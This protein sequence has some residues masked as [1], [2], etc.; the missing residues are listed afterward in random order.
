MSGIAVRFCPE[1]S[2]PSADGA[3]RLL[4]AIKQRGAD[5]QIAAVVGR[6]EVA[7][8]AFH[9]SPEAAAE[10][11]P[12]HHPTL[13][14]WLVADA[15][16]D[17]RVALKR[18][19]LDSGCSF[20]PHTDAE[21]ILAAHEV[22]GANAQ[23][24]LVGDFAYVLWANGSLLAARDVMGMRPLVWAVCA[25]GGL[26]I[27]STLACV[28][29]FFGPTPSINLRHIAETL[30]NR[31]SNRTDTPYTGV[32]RLGPGERLVLR[33]GASPE[34]Q[35]IDELK[36]G[37]PL[38]VDAEQ[39]VN[40]V[41]DMLATSVRDR[42]RSIGGIACEVSGGLDS[43]TVFGLTCDVVGPSRITALSHTYPGMACDESG[44]IDAVVQS[45]RTESIA[46]D[47]SFTDPREL[48]RQVAADGEIPRYPDNARELYALAHRAGCRVVLTGQGGDE[49][50]SYSAGVEADLFRERSACVVLGSLRGHGVGASIFFLRKLLADV[51][52]FEVSKRTWLAPL[53]GRWRRRRF[54]HWY[55]WITESLWAE[56]S[57]DDT[58]R[59]VV[60]GAWAIGRSARLQSYTSPS[61]ILDYERMDRDAAGVL[62]VSHPFADR[63]F[64]ELMLQLPSNVVNPHGEARFLHRL[65]FGD[66]MPAIVRDREDK[67]EFGERYPPIVRRV[68]EQGLWTH[69]EGLTID[70]PGVLESDQDGGD[71]HR[72]WPLV[73]VSAWGRAQELGAGAC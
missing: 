54:R 20:L 33:P 11:Y 30:I 69:D 68:V 43:S 52:R 3:A 58:S 29:E 67:A 22:W 13:D 63:R 15:R 48:E 7:H 10:S 6:V 71:L 39:A 23:Q 65:A 38:S 16:I 5:R 37:A 42:A 4:H 47:A 59:A 9:A 60:Q 46:V 35:V 8:A 1:A 2:G 28:L 24:K 19:L 44:Y 49:A 45:G 56:I 34:V 25:D 61:S 70:S 55:P 41:R 51:L 40:L 14:M 53:L 26:V 36:V 66:K 32:Q 50:F 17:D 57:F 18:R 64:V 72:V 73:C 21:L 31:P 62:E 12:V 27:A